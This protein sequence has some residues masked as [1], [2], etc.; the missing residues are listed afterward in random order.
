MLRKVITTCVSENN[1]MKNEILSKDSTWKEDREF[2]KRCEGADA[3]P[4]SEAS[5]WDTRFPHQSP[6]VRCLAPASRQCRLWRAAVIAQAIGFLL[7]ASS[8]VRGHCGHLGSEI[9]GGCCCFY[10]EFGFT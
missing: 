2:Q 9:A 6:W 4:G 3:W 8:Q 7:P 5:T 10:F 1:K